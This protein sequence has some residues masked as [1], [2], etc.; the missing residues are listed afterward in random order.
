MMILEI[1]GKVANHFDAQAQLIE[2]EIAQ[3]RWK[4]PEEI[5]Y[6]KGRANAFKEA[7]KYLK[8]IGR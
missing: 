7:A 3:M 6:Q 4:R 1:L 2:H 8:V 5:V